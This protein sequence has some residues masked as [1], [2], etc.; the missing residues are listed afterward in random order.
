MNRSRVL[1]LAAVS[2][3]TAAALLLTGCGGDDSGS[4][5]KSKDKA[6]GS[7][8]KKQE[9]AG[10]ETGGADGADQAPEVDRP[11]MKFP[12]DMNMIFEKTKLSDPDQAAALNDAENYARSTV[13]G[14]IKQDP[15]DAAYKFYSEPK[16]PAA[17]YAKYQIDKHASGDLSLS[18]ERRHSDAKV[19]PAKGGGKKGGFVV[20]FCSDDSKIKGKD[21]QSGTTFPFEPGLQNFWLWTVDMVPSKST[22]GLWVAHD[23]VV[24]DKAKECQ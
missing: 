7:D 15:E 1:P 4:A 6:A 18:G 24:K 23:V 16:S 10:A 8:A 11:A 2:L 5:D 12:K 21:L 17:K 3:T 9:S 20:T 13:Y 22:E 19:Q 14:I